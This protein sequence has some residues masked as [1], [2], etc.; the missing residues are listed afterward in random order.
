MALTN[1]NP[2][3]TVDTLRFLMKLSK[4]IELFENYG[5]EKLIKDA[6]AIS[7]REQKRANEARENIAKYE[8]LIAE[9]K[10]L[11]KKNEDDATANIEKSKQLTEEWSRLSKEAGELKKWEADV[12]KQ[13]EENRQSKAALLERERA[14]EVKE[15]KLAEAKADVDATKKE[16]DK[17]TSELKARAAK[18]QGLAEGL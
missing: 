13:V 12:N 6:E 7:E 11:Q 9:H 5:L 15:S 14:I 8:S 18:I 17:L 3:E 1:D 2:R 4:G 10:Q 16:A